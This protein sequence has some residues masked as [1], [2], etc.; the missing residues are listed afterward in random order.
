MLLTCASIKGPERQ[1]VKDWKTASIREDNAIT[2]RKEGQ[3]NNGNFAAYKGRLSVLAL[4]G[5]NQLHYL[6]LLL[7]YILIT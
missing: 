4:Y 1:R 7:T 5:M 2:G 3:L 6:K